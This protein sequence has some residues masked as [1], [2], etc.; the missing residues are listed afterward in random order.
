LRVSFVEEGRK[1]QRP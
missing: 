1:R